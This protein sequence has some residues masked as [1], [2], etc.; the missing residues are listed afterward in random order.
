LIA[1][2]AE[3]RPLRLLPEIRVGTERYPE[4]VARRLRAVN[5]STWSGAA[6]L[7]WF[8]LLRLLDPAPGMRTRSFVALGFAVAMALVPLLHRFNSLAAPLA[9]LALGYVYLFRTIYQHGMARGSYL[10]YFSATAFGI[11]LVGTEHV[12]IALTLGAV[13]TALII[14]LHLIVPYSTGLLPPPGAFIVNVMANSAI[15]FGVFF[16][17]MRQIIRS[18]AAT[19]TLR[20]HTPVQPMRLR[21]MVNQLL[22]SYERTIAPAAE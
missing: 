13:A 10:F 5:I 18:E 22:Q 3:P 9:F 4:K 6:I 8:A 12:L 1:N 17:A 19:E 11:L 21:A 16:Y 7:A 2:I 20:V 14:V 15:L